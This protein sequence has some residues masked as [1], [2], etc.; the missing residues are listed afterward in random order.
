MGDACL[1]ERSAS[2][3]EVQTPVGD[4]EATQRLLEA[5]GFEAVR[6]QENYRDEWRLDDVIFDFDTWPDLPTFVEVEGPDETTVRQA[7]ATLDL[8][9][10]LATFGA[11]DELYQRE[12]GR[13]ILKERQLTFDRTL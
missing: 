9:F 12:L 4:F 11:V 6:Y 3:L 13:D 10:T 5:V 7:S 8:D 1:P 2:V